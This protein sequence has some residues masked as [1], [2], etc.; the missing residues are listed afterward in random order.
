MEAYRQSRAEE[1]SKMAG[2]SHLWEEEGRKKGLKEGLK[3]GFKEGRQ[4][5]VR[6]GGSRVLMHQM[7]LKF[8]E[9][10]DEVRQKIESADEETLLR[11]SERLLDAKTVEDVFEL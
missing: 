6:T 1:V 11:W 4:E 8:G 3:E 7:T 2:L 9:L 10:S 5:G